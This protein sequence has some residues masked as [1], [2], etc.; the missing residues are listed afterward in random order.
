VVVALLSG[1]GWLMARPIL[2]ASPTPG[3]VIQ[4]QAT[5][6]FVD[7][8]DSNPNTNTK[9][10]E[11]NIVQVTVAEVAALSVAATGSSG[12]P[13]AGNS[14][15]F[16]FTIR[17]D[18]N[19]S[20]QFTIPG[21][22]T[23]VGGTLNDIQII[24]YDPDGAGPAAAVPVNKTVASGGVDTGAATAIGLPGGA[25][26][27]LGTVLVRVGVTVTGAAGTTVSAQLSVTTKDNPDSTGSNNIPA[28]EASGVPLG[29]EK[30]ANATNSTTI[31]NSVLDYGD[32][33]N[34][35]GTLLASDG[36]R[37]A[38]TGLY[39]GAGVSADTDGQPNA[40][41][42]ADTNDDG[43][44]FSPTLGSNY[45]TLIQAGVSNQV[46]VISSGVGFVNAWVDYNQNGVFET[47]ERILTNQAVVAGTNPLTFTPPDT[48][49]HGST[50]ARFRLSPNLVDSP[51][52]TGSITGGEVEDSQV[53]VA[54]PVPDGDACSTTGL[55]NGS[56]EVP[57]QDA[58]SFIIQSENNIPGWNTT[59]TDKQIKTW[60]TGF[61]GVPS[62]AGN[63]F[64]E[65][66][67]NEVAAL[68]QDIA[69]VPGA[70]ITYQFAHRARSAD[71]SVVVDVGSIQAG[72]PGTLAT[73]R[74]IGTDSTDWIVYRGTYVVP[75][76]QYITRFQFNSISSGAGS[77]SFGNFLDAVQF[78]TSTCVT[79]ISPPTI[80]LDGNNSAAP[81]NDYLNTFTVGGVAVAAAD[82]DVVITDEKTN[83]TRAIF[84]LTN[85]PDGAN[86][87]LTVDPT[88]GG[89]VTGVSIDSA[90]DATV[91]TSTT[92]RLTLKGSATLADYQ[93]VIA[94]LKYSNTKVSPTLSDRIINVQVVDSDKAIGNT[95]TSTI[96]LVSGLT[97]SG[98]VFSDADADIVI[99]GSDA[100]T[101]AGSTTLTIYALDSSGKVL[102]KA[103]VAA[104]GIYT[105]TSVP[106]NRNIKLRLSNDNTFAIGATPP[107]APTIPSI[108]S[109]W[110]FTGE[111]LNG[112]IDPVIATLGDI[113]LSTTTLNLTNENF[114]IR[115][116]Y[117]IA[118]DPA[119]ATCT[120]DFRTALNTGIDASGVAL[121]VGSNDLNWT[122]EWI[123]GPASGIYT[124][125]AT[126]RPVGVMP[127][128][129]TGNL[130][131]G[132][133]INDLANAKWISYPFRI[134]PNSTGNHNDANLNGSSNQ[135]TDTVRIKYTATVT[136][137]SNANTISVSVPVGVSVDNQF[138]SA[139]VNGVEN[140]V[141]PTPD[142]Y[143]EDYHS[144]QSFNLSQGWV[145]GVNTIEIVTDSGPP[146][147]GFFLGVNAATTQVC[148]GNSPNVLLVK[149][150]TGV[151]GSPNNGSISL[152]TYDPETDTNSS[153]YA[154]DKNIIQSGLT[155]P[156]SDKWPNTTGAAN[157]TFL[158]GARNGGTAS[159]GAEIEYTIY[160]LSAGSE[161]AK[162]V[163]ICDRI[164][165]Y[166]TFIPDAFN[167]LTTAPNTAP[168]APIGDRGIAVSQGNVI[169]GYTNIG[170]GDAARYYPPGSTLPSACT[171][172]AL[173]EDNG[174]IVVN[175][176]D[177]PN[178]TSPGVPAES[179]GFFRFR[180]KVK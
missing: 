4:N 63:Q 114:G 146:L 3:T 153:S 142:A 93:K 13:S 85:T 15:Y 1:G 150:I 67:A 113:S 144:L 111:N 83:I 178:A 163:T 140:I 40:T 16:D 129:V 134:A 29:G 51:S 102:D 49:L 26:L 98:T 94:T 174:T 22:A 99:N 143:T 82:T 55:L 95:A 167:S 120:P 149:R 135:Q 139:K 53:N 32:A 117:T 75:A 103:A 158:L 177:V 141:P 48:V 64:A 145:A 126:P 154:Y 18:G 133:W 137:P 130:A 90:Y 104:N 47:T 43:I 66:N 131:P 156:S 45:S 108:P 115:Q 68:Y 65:L 155:P 165:R 84:T 180:A 124:P 25:I 21:T 157:S 44:T 169:Y 86:E 171:Q 8:S 56:F 119:P 57:V 50:V 125:Y 100:G 132:A 116:S 24:S 19:D 89:T 172:P 62:F 166:Q 2:A 101:N 12:T 138:V 170:D 81:G 92:G 35:Y 179:Y 69:T 72:S 161:S 87:S 79:P 27:P 31:A 175:L 168:T 5:G 118:A 28:T 42:S 176:G 107:T 122:A 52:P 105:L 110:F 74:T 60:S 162:N 123:A 14:V 173:V 96:K 151:D 91:G 10:I 121:S 148:D 7:S 159:T 160:F 6:S 77:N 80:D 106:A 59:A 20:T 9:S 46:T 17:N 36:A 39:L 33:P 164:P 34:S 128:V 71:G 152:G 23:L 61:N 109:G 112:T 70:T 38:I 76:G 73:L 97:V 127:A 78:S 37:H 11:S 88:A 147:T 30:T 41:A 54:A 58:N 136:L